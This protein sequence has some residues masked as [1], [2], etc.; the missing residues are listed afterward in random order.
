M[1]RVKFVVVVLLAVPSFVLS[2]VG[3]VVV[4]VWRSL[5]NGAVLLDEIADWVDS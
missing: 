1:N 4:Y 5:A 2:L 3:L